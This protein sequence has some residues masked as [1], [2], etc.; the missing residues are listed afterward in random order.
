MY[1]KGANMLHTL[2]QLVEDDEKWRQMLR[3]LNMEF[4]HQTVTTKQ[5]EEY[6]SEFLEKDLTEFF[7]QYLRTTKIPTLEYKIERKN[8]EYRYTNIIESFDTVSY[9]H[10]TLPTTPYV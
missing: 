1:Y 5:V 9:T 8:L 6:M 10:L 4:Y 7:N 2:R 3:G